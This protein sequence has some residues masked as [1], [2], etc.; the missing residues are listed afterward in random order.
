MIAAIPAVKAKTLVVYCSDGRFARVSDE[1]VE[2]TLKIADYDVLAMPG[3][4]QF[5]CALE[6]LPKL[7]WAGRRWLDYLVEGH[8][9]ERVVLITHQDCG[10][11]R[12]LHGSHDD[13]TTRQREDLRRARTELLEA[14]PHLGVEAYFVS[15]QD[16][17]VSFTKLE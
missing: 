4:P 11:Y 15:V 17:Q 2:Q 16:G 9:L 12:R 5:L 1:F 3:G 6:Y 14:L 8:G 10:W 7:R 13:H